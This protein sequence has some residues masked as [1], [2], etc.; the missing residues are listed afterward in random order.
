METRDFA[1]RIVT[2]DTLA[3]KLRAAPRELTDR[4]P[5]PSLRLVRPGRPASLAIVP[6]SR[7]KV[8]SIEGMA[9]PAQRVRILH[10]LANHELQA[11]E[12]FAWALLAFAGAPPEFRAGLV[13]LVAEEQRHCRMYIA[14]LRDFGATLGDHSVS[15]YFWSKVRTLTTPLRFVCAMGLTFENANLDHAAEYAAAARAAGDRK[16][17]ALLDLVGDEEVGHVRF[18]WRWL[19]EWKEPGQSMWNAYAANVTWPLRAA[20]ARGRVFHAERRAAAG[21]DAEFIRLLASA[22]RA[23]PARKAQR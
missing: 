13:Q 10:A 21:L 16:T 4:D 9:D 5:G 17:A 18:G 11:V 19:A 3:S 8:P 23:Q 14:R 7:A 2:G 20:L 6:S 1:L 22:D 12:L 15:G